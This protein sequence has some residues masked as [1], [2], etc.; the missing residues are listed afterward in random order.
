[1][2]HPLLSLVSTARLPEP[3]QDE[4]WRSVA[5]LHSSGWSRDEVDQA[6]RVAFTVAGELLVRNQQPLVI[7]D[8]QDSSPF[9]AIRLPVFCP[10]RSATEMSQQLRARL[11]TRGLDRPGL[12]ISFWSIIP[13]ERARLRGQ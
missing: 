5:A 8:D 12:S 6:I 11:Q 9:V 7:C 1:M 4:L 13:R 10:A 2:E 3:E